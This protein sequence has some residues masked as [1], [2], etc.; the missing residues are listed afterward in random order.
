MAPRTR[1]GNR[2]LGAAIR[3][4]RATLGLSIEEAAAKAGIGAKSW[5]RY[6]SGAAIREDKVRGVCK[7]LGWSKLPGGQHADKEASAA[8]LQKIDRSHDAWSEALEKDWGR[9]CAVTFAVGSDL[10]GDQLA[11]DLTALAREPRGT[12]LGQLAASWLDGQLPPQFVPRYDYEFIYTLRAAVGTLRERFTA[13]NLV[14]HS[15]L[16]ELALHLILGQADLLA[17]IDP[18]L[19][20]AGDDWREWLGDILGD[21]D[22]EYLLFN[23]SRA[24]TPD[25]SY[26]F[27][28]WMESQFYT[29]H[30]RITD[31][32][33]AV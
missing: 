30:S 20:E 22:I 24:L 33:D 17:G 29:D 11:E 21:L 5:G 10:L 19:F 8:W 9:A 4:R 1:A 26:H 23:L 2:E 16:E 18:E 6:E 31:E 7:A 15:V 27:D 25:I 14:A 28:H 12:H 13:G 3:G 32:P